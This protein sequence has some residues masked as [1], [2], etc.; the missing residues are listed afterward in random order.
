MVILKEIS[1]INYRKSN[2]Q[3]LFEDKQV[4][5]M[6]AIVSNDI[7]GF[8]FGWQS[9]IVKPVE[10]EVSSEIYAI[11]ID[12]NFIIIDLSLVSIRLRLELELNYFFL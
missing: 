4:D 7:Y 8:K 12:Q 2:F 11:G 3:I 10:K 6:F 1:E 5:K 9:T